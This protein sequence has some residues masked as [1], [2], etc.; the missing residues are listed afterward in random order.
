MD[1]LYPQRRYPQNHGYG[2]RYLAVYLLHMSIDAIMGTI[3]LADSSGPT[4][5]DSTLTN[6]PKPCLMLITQ[7]S[8][9]LPQIV[10][11]TLENGVNAVQWKETRGVGMGFNR[12]YAD[13][14]AVTKETV[15]L[16]VN[17]DWQ[18]AQRLHVRNLHL[19]EKSMPIGVV[20]H[21]LGDRT[22]VG[23]TVHS[24]QAA[25]TAASQGADYLQAGSIFQSVSEPDL[26]PLGIQFLKEV[27]AVVKIPVLAYGGIAPDDI[28]DC[29]RAGA[30]GIAISSG[31]MGATSPSDA[32]VS[33]SEALHEAWGNRPSAPAD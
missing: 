31:I 13:L 16:I 18:R 3:K 24:V 14:T 26:Q 5:K 23:K 10:A 32:A 7:P 12:A 2:S 21:H 9:R 28:E 33:F 30:A 11:D 15:T 20:R 19:P 8:P 1:G 4:I 6:L 29:I 27:C 25:I 17:G 22:F